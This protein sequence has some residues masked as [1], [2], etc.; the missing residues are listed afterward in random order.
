MKPELLTTAQTAIIERVGLIDTKDALIIELS[1]KLDAQKRIAEQMQ[2]NVDLSTQQS[3]AL[4]NELLCVKFNSYYF[5][6]Y[7]EGRYEPNKWNFPISDKV[8]LVG[9]GIS[10]EEQVA[11]IRE[12][13]QSHKEDQ[14]E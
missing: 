14:D 11:W 1:F 4:K 8:F 12:Y 7:P 13:E 5:K 10:L 3:N 9:I 6:T 2:A